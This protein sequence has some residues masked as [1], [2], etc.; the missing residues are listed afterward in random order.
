[1]NAIVEEQERWNLAPAPSHDICQLHGEQSKLDVIQFESAK[2][3]K[4]TNMH[5]ST[6][7]GKLE[8]ELERLRRKKAGLEN[9]FKHQQVR[10]ETI[11]KQV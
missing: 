4:R 5:V 9:N 11:R 10:L 1:M 7:M 3:S 6:L 8:K 2:W